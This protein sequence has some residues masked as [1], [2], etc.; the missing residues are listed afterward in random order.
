MIVKELTIDENLLHLQ[1]ILFDLD[2]YKFDKDILKLLD[3][4]KFLVDKKMFSNF[5]LENYDIENQEVILKFY[6]IDLTKN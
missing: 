4:L 6:L 3:E 2:S 1:N 5:N